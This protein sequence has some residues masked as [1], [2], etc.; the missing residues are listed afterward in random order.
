M[1]GSLDQLQ[2]KGRDGANRS[3]I[4]QSHGMLVDEPD[5]QKWGIT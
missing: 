5:I 1:G 3:P 2:E 4:S